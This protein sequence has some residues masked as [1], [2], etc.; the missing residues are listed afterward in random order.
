MDAALTEAH[1]VWSA[2]G[3][4]DWRRPVRYRDGD[5][6]TVLLSWW[7]ELEIHTADAEL[8]S[9]PSGWSREFCAHVLDHLGRRAP[10]GV[11]LELVATDRPGGPDGSGGTGRW[12]HGTGEPVRVRGALTDLAAWLAG[13]EPRGALDFP[14]SGRPLLRPWP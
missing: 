3:P 7:R 2:V 10:E 5:L 12:V 9:G 8:G 1:R 11:A 14:D 13:R 4:K 6:V